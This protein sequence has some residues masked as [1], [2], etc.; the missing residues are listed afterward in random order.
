MYFSAL[1]GYLFTNNPE[2]A[3]A[4][5]RLW[6]SLGFIMAFGYSSFRCTDLKLYVC[7]AFLTVGM[8]LY[9]VTELLQRTKARSVDFTR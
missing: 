4:N 8:L 3:F 9:G 7:I 5:Y 2:A 1:Y 6:E